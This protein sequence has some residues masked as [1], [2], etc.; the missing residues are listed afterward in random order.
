MTIVIDDV[1]GD[2]KRPYHSVLAADKVEGLVMAAIRSASS[3]KKGDE[4]PLILIHGIGAS[5]DSSFDGLVAA[6]EV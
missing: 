2:L 3:G 5:P 4:P 1:A 6:T